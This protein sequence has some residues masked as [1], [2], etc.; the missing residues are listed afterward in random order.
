MDEGLFQGSRFRLVS[1]HGVQARL[2]VE[3]SAP[4]GKIVLRLG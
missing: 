4:I 1:G 2:I 3:N